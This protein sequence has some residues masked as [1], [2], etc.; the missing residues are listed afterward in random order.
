MHTV[1]AAWLNLR[2]GDLVAMPNGTSCGKYARDM[3]STFLQVD[4][5]PPGPGLSSQPDVGLIVE[6]LDLDLGVATARPPAPETVVAGRL[7]LG[8]GAELA[9]GGKTAPI[10]LAVEAGS[11]GLVVE[12]EGEVI[13]RAGTDKY[14]PSEVLRAG[15]A[16]TLGSGDAAYLPPHPGGSLAN[17][18]AEAL[19]LF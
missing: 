5:F 18:G 16:V 9:L 14:A 2:A 13:R 1:P 4:G 8:P 6:L 3:D 15:T 7:T 19:K 12:V 17:T 11:A 10:L